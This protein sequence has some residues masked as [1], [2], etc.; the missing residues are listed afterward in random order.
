MRSNQ[1][2]LK[3]YYTTF[4]P[5][6]T[7]LLQSWIWIWCL[8]QNNQNFR[9]YRSLLSGVPKV[10]R[11]ILTGQKVKKKVKVETRLPPLSLWSTQKLLYWEKQFLDPPAL[12]S[13]RLC[14]STAP[15]SLQYWSLMASSSHP[16]IQGKSGEP[17]S[18]LSVVEDILWLGFSVS[19]GL[20]RRRSPETA[21]V[22]L[23]MTTFGVLRKTKMLLFSFL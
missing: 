9:S 11:T 19:E 16:M 15:K 5:L 6:S 7:I 12:V 23:R 4:S 20:V 13:S 2:F 14:S 18:S 21:Q 22:L 10:T 8:L 3:W 1:T 17:R